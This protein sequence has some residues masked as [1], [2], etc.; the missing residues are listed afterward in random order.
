MKYAKRGYY[1]TPLCLLLL[2]ALLQFMPKVMQAQSTAYIYRDSVYMAVPGLMNK[3][4]EIDSIKTLYTAE[5]KQGQDN[6]QAK[7]NTL[8]TSYQPKEGENINLLKKRMSAA[9][10]LQLNLLTE[11]DKMQQLKIKSYESMIQAR[12]QHEIVPVLN[13]VNA[14]V[15]SYAL[16]N[17]LDFIFIME[18]ITPALMY[19]NKS[20]NVTA[21]IIKLVAR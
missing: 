3:M 11:E 4:K 1:N 7:L 15:E 10:T 13:K 12:Y 20:K 18:Q 2:T 21:D 16:R 19:M 5:I 14:A 6:L 17:K 8:I 9:D